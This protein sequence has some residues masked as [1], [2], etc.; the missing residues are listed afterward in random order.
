MSAAWENFKNTVGQKWENFKGAMS[1]FGDKIAE[2]LIEQAK[3][4]WDEINK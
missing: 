2:K 3:N 1:E 4:R